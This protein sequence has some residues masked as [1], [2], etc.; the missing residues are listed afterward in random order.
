MQ[1]E[2]RNVERAFEDFDN[3]GLVLTDFELVNFAGQD[4][5]FDYVAQLTAIYTLVAHQNYFDNE[6]SEEIKRVQGIAETSTGEANYRAV[7]RAVD[8][9]HESAYQG[10]AHSMA[11][12]GMLAPFIESIFR[13]AFRVV[14][15]EWPRN[16]MA[17]N[18]IK[19]IND[20]NLGLSEYMPKGLE[21]TLEALFSYRNKMLHFG[22]HWPEEE[23]TRF[24]GRLSDWP[25]HWFDIATSGGRPWMF[26]MSS[27]FITHCLDTTVEI[28]KGFARYRLG[29]PPTGSYLQFA[30][31][32][33][34]E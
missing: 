6:L 16:D 4:T 21:P 1:E 33:D 34:F 3:E 7:D 26:Y 2:T 24:N 14:E 9:M 31:D 5:E 12:V 17:K 32:D 13:L 30:L 22:F 23:R 19:V 10:I 11:V 18:L 27:E 8:M 25:S 28:L 20:E 29:I 15:R